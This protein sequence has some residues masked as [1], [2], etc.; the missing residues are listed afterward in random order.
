EGVG[1]RFEFDFRRIRVF[2]DHFGFGDGFAGLVFDRHVVGDR[3]DVGEVDRG[4]A[5]FGGGVFGGVGEFAAFGRFEVDDRAGAGG[6]AFGFAAGFG[7]AFGLGFSAGV[8]GVVVGAA[9]G[10]EPE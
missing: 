8:A 3:L 7:G 4:R 6:A 10:D 2:G 1:A 5:G 9:A